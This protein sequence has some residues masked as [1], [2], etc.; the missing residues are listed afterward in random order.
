MASSVVYRP[1]Y[2]AFC[3]QPPRC[4]LLCL[5]SRASSSRQIARIGASVRVPKNHIFRVS[6]SFAQPVLPSD[7][8]CV[9]VQGR[10]KSLQILLSDSQ[11]GPG[12]KAMQGQEE[13]SRNHVQGTFSR[14]CSLYI[15]VELARGRKLYSDR[16]ISLLYLKRAKWLPYLLHT[17]SMRLVDVDGWHAAVECIFTGTTEARNAI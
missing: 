5:S 12:R 15:K 7:I 8:R 6:P 3:P 1:K 17:P 9:H 11:A 2:P 4:F 10:E 16:L 14:L 13:M